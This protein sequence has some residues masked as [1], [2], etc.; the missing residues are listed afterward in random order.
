M[1][2][3]I[4]WNE[5]QWQPRA[6]IAQTAYR[7]LWSGLAYAVTHPTGHV[8]GRVIGRQGAGSARRSGPSEV[9]GRGSAFGQP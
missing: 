3:D 5:R 8:A 7:T 1:R 9:T 2:P 4:A 6:P